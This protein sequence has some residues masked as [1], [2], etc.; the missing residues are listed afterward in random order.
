[1][2]CNVTHSV[3]DNITVVKD[4]TAIV[5]IFLKQKRRSKTSACTVL[6]AR[7]YFDDT[8]VVFWPGTDFKYL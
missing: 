1:M 5:E 3:D 2:F 8:S 7:F 6:L 4:N